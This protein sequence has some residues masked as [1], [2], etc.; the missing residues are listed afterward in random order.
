[1]SAFAG[2]CRRAADR[3]RRNRDCFIPNIKYPPDVES[4]IQDAAEKFQ[5][6][7]DGADGEAAR[8]MLK[9]SGKFVEFGRD[10]HGVVDFF[11]GEGHHR[12]FGTLLVQTNPYASYGIVRS[13][14]ESEPGR[15]PKG[16]MPWLK[17]KLWE[18]VDAAPK[19]KRARKPKKPA[20]YAVSDGTAGCER[21]G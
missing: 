14:L 7:W 9:E 16:F 2:R 6:F 11:H 15:E 5:K 20:A 21:Q 13:W 3:Y 12:M 18:I 17:S 8:K 4:E 10:E 19:P 1:M